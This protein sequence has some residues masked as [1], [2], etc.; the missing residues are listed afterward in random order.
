MHAVSDD[1]PTAI[2]AGWVRFEDGRIVS[3]GQGEPPQAALKGARHID[4]EGLSLVPGFISGPS[5]IGLLEV[6]Q[7]SAT[8][9][10][11]EGASRSPAA[12][13]WIAV[14]P[15]SDLIPVARS[16]GVLHTLAMPS[17]EGV[18]HLLQQVVRL[19]QP[20]AL[21]KLPPAPR[22][23]AARRRGG[24]L[25]PKPRARSSGGGRGSRIHSPIEA[26]VPDSC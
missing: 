14:N 19:F 10:R 4:A 12:A 9:D 25:S 16:G 21:P 15:D 22:F 3:M 20:S 18:Q 6:E 17:G 7:V 2:D 13:A 24:I 11:R 1:H 26:E 5:Q 23:A 8:D